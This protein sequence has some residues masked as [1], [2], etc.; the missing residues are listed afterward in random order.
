[1]TDLIQSIAIF[2]VALG[3]L[4]NSLN[5]KKV[6]K[7]VMSMQETIEHLIKSEGSQNNAISRLTSL[8]K[9]RLFYEE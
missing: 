5:G 9:G 6:L 8:I 4:F 3:L 7:I 1:M 2:A